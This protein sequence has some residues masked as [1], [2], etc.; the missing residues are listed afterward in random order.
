[1]VYNQQ[2][3]LIWNKPS[4]EGGPLSASGHGR[5]KAPIFS[6]P[7]LLSRCSAS[8]GLCGRQQW[9]RRTIVNVA[10]NQKCCFNNLWNCHCEEEFFSAI[11][12]RTSF[13]HLTDYNHEVISTA[14]KGQHRGVWIRDLQ[15]H[16]VIIQYAD[17]IFI[18]SYPD[19]TVFQWGRQNRLERK[20]I[21]NSGIS[22]P[23]QNDVFDK[24][25]EI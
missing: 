24:N 23:P 22:W 3:Q 1:M 17:T 5:K 9:R 6:L 8:W 12:S 4:E 10:G 16:C 15:M 13:F 20:K 7:G 21:I 18:H 19:W 11:F 2:N 25:V 14:S